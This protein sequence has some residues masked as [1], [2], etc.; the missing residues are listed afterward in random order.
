MSN[1][2]ICQTTWYTIYRRIEEEEGEQLKGGK[3]LTDGLLIMIAKHALSQYFCTSYNI[4]KE[5][6]LMINFGTV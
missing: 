3:K 2:S 5:K 4:Y 1:F 6:V